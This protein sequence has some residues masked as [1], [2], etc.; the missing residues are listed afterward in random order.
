[1]LKRFVKVWNGYYLRQI[2]YISKYTSPL[3]KKSIISDPKKI[4]F[5]ERIYLIYQFYNLRRNYF[6]RVILL[7]FL[8]FFII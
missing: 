2:Y 3:R 8:V 4:Y 7:F 5:K 1:M 6:D